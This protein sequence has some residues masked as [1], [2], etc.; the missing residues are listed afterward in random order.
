MCVRY[1]RGGT[2]DGDSIPGQRDLVLYHLLVSLGHGTSLAHSSTPELSSVVRARCVAAEARVLLF[3][4]ADK[5]D[6]GTCQVLFL[7][8]ALHSGHH[9]YTWADKGW[10]KWQTQ[11]G[12]LTATFCTLQGYVGKRSGKQMLPTDFNWT[13]LEG[14]SL[15]ARAWAEPTHALAKLVLRMTLHTRV[16][17]SHFPERLS[18]FPRVAQPG[19]AECK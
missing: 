2:A 17:F 3:G 4:L 13:K 14:H 12:I 1:G 7:T 18:D 10:W 5:E 15:T 19:N 8:R 9:T 16:H 11:T 6:W